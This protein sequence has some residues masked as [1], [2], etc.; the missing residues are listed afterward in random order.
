MIIL[1]LDTGTKTGWCLLKD[2]K[3]VESGVQDFSKLRGESNGALFLKFRTWLN[4]ILQE[5]RVK[6]VAYEMAHHR[7]GAATEICVNL[8]GRVEEV[9]HELGIEFTGV[10]SM[11]LKK[12]ATGKGNA[13]KSRMIEVAKSALDR[14]PIDDNEADSVL[15][16]MYGYANY[17]G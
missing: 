2:G 5:Q 10:P 1:G 6:F 11:T 17:G 16:A 14:E 3:I 15:L 4:H 9:C 13:D 7:G 12:W 8:T